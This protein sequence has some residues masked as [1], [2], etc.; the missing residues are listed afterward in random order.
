MMRDVTTFCLDIHARYQCRHAGACCESWS[1]PA[2]PR[3]VEL[4]R[5]RKVRRSGIEG[6]MFVSSLESGEPQEWMVARD[7]RGDCVFFD[8][9]AGRLC[10]I[11]RDLGPDALPSACRHFPRKV[12]IDPRGVLISLT[13]FC[14]TAAA[15]LLTRGELAIV[16]AFPPLKL[17]PPTEGL[18]AR[19][20]LPPLVR[21]GLLCDIQ[22][23]DAW[24]RSALTVFADADHD[25]ATCL[26]IVAAATESIRTWRP[27]T[28][29]LADRVATDFQTARS[30]HQTHDWSS[31]RAIARLRSLTMGQVGDDLLPIESFDDKW[32]DYPGRRLAWFDAGMKKYLGARLFANWIAYQGRGLR[33]IVEWLRTCAALVGHELLRQTNGSTSP[34]D[35]A[36]FIEAVRSADLLLLHVLDSASFARQVATIEGP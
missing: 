20:A 35:V 6:D 8:R 30:S 24:E 26:D 28:A 23:Y 34:P 5:T 27:D 2:E 7:G 32:N 18:D 11:H 36:T 4:V 3:V 16:E 29:S 13:H 31:S 25:F 19:D 1:V 17:D 15:T 9:D 10:V 21:P 12:V 14:P 22:G 33:T